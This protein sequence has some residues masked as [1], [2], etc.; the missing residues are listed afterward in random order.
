MIIENKIHKV[1]DIEFSIKYSGRR[2][3]GISIS[4]DSGVVARVPYRTGEKEI[5]RMIHNKAAWIRRILNKH[6]SLLKLDENRSLTDRESVLLMGK[7][8][9]LKLIPSERYYIRKS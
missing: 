9:Y 6:K 3:L 5:E 7:E 2:T 1:D 8:H 4:P